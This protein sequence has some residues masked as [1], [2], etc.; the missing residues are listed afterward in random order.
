MFF[1]SGSTGRPKGVLHTHRS[2]LA[3]LTSTCEAL[4]GADPSDSILVCEPLVHPSGF[5]ATF[6]VLLRGGT[7]G[8]L[9]G[10]DEARYIA[11]AAM[12]CR[13]RGSTNSGP[14]PACRSR[15]DGA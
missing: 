9:A 15:S 4:D 5:I 6:S 8:L 12:W 11:A 7:V 3:I 1:I 14:S 10:F 13:R 2:A